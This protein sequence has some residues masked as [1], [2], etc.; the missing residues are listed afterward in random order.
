[1]PWKCRNH[2]KQHMLGRRH[3]SKRHTSHNDGFAIFTPR[4]G[5]DSTNTF[6]MRQW[7]IH[8]NIH[9]VQCVG[10]SKTA[11]LKHGPVAPTYT[12]SIQIHVVQSSPDAQSS[13][14]GEGAQHRGQRARQLIWAEVPGCSKT[15]TANV[16]CDELWSTRRVGA[17][18]LPGCN[19]PNKAIGVLACTTSF[20]TI[21]NFGKLFPNTALGWC[22]RP[23]SAK[24]TDIFWKGLTIIS[25]LSFVK[26][27]WI[28]GW[29][30]PTDLH[31]RAASDIRKVHRT[32]LV[33]CR[34]T[35][36]R[37]VGSLPFGREAT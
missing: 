31:V 35:S 4:E 18:G 8:M 24:E 26:Q 10:P 37:V 30:N 27:R 29:Y 6:A 25:M 15:T 3:W 36:H 19:E 17:L 2:W 32:N 11:M 23:E 20:E 22:D 12:P 7:T 33:D 34:V 5:D 28:Y 16:A 14:A 21:V 9:K 13:E 1:M